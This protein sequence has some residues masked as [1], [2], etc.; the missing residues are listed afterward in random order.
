MQAAWFYL[1]VVLSNGMC[2]SVIVCV[3]MNN[4]RVWLFIWCRERWMCLL[5]F[6]LVTE[7]LGSSLTKN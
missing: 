1:S 6:V 7:I 5:H 4:A 2:H 3:C